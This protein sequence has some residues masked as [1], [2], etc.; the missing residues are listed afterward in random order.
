M[1]VTTRSRTERPV[2]T[3]R[4]RRRLLR[5]R[6][7]IVKANIWANSI[8]AIA[9]SG[10][11]ARSSQELRTTVVRDPEDPAVEQLR[12]ERRA[13]ARKALARGDRGYFLWVGDS[14]A[15]W[16][17]VAKQTHRD[18]WSGIKFRLQPGDAFLYDLWMEADRRGTRHTLALTDWTA[19]NLKND[20][21]V[22]RVFTLIEADNH[23]SMLLV[24]RYGFSVIQQVGI[25]RFAGRIGWH[26]P[27]TNRPNSGP[28]S[29][30]EEPDAARALLDVDAA[31]RP[32]D[33][34]ALDL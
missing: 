34:E 21:E 33:H 20:P 7:E 28:A 23:S 2:P 8:D 19:T 24:Q 14:L 9:V 16:H 1:S 26:V 32:G 22:K 25:V 18:T 27:W 30:R 5:G 17:W 29:R 12:P 10:V 3:R 13:F 6:V 11:R 31:D 15:G 4:P